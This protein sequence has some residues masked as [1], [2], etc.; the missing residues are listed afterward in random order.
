MHEP[1][2]DGA[3]DLCAPVADEPAPRFARSTFNLSVISAAL[4]AGLG[5]AKVL[6]WTNS[7]VADGLLVAGV[8]IAGASALASKTPEDRSAPAVVGVFVL[9]A[10]VVTGMARIAQP[11]RGQESEAVQEIADSPPAEQFDTDSEQ[12]CALPAGDSAIP[13]I[14]EDGIDRTLLVTM[15]VLDRVRNCWVRSLPVA[16]AEDGSSRSPIQPADKVDFQI[17]VENAG[18]VR[19]ENLMVKTTLAASLMFV[20]DSTYF[21]SSRFPDG[22]QISNNN[23]IAGGLNFGNYAPGGVGYI[24]FS[25]HAPFAADLQCGTTSFLSV[26]STHADG[27]NKHVNTAAFDVESQVRCDEAPIVRL[28]AEADAKKPQ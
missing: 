24:K 23:L 10:L 16:V 27:T 7:I 19:I 6:G 8:V 4:S 26:V 3:I 9:I 17:R 20:P 25:V 2:T 14:R 13:T 11:S 21:K 12:V 22:V 28:T 5:V 1:A 18:D 15:W